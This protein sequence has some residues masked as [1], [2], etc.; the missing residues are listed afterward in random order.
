MK[1]YVD[2]L[3]ENCWKCIFADNQKGY[4][5]LLETRI[6]RQFTRRAIGCPLKSLAEH[7]KQVKKE[8]VQELKDKMLFCSER[9]A[10]NTHYYNGKE[11][12]EILDKLQ[13]EDNV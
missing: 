4:C 9:F 13:G 11:L 2:E 7:D 10:D 8:V 3:P 12:D 6:L 1:A 5:D